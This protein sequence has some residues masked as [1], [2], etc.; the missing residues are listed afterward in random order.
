MRKHAIQNKRVL[1]KHV[2][3]NV[4]IVKSVK[5]ILVGILGQV[6]VKITSIKKVLIII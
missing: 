5:W 1:I 3:V 4:K 2:N 6:F